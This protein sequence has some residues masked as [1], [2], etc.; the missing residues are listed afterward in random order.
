M[1]AQLGLSEASLRMRSAA[2]GTMTFCPVAFGG[3]PS[4]VIDAL[5]SGEEAQKA[6]EGPTP[7]AG[8]G[9]VAPNLL[10]V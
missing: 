2:H 9:I 3:L 7:T 4:E 1:H 10:S 5:Q 8:N 6:T